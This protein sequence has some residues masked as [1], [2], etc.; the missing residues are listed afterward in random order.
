MKS[1]PDCGGEVTTIRALNADGSLDEIVGHGD[2]HLEQLSEGAWF[3]QLGG[4][5]LTIY[6]PG[7]AHVR[8]NPI[9]HDTWE[10][11]RA[12]VNERKPV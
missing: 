4:I 9:D 6:T 1:Y 2:F 8:T 12:A 11:A 10:A 5:S 7:R 3:L